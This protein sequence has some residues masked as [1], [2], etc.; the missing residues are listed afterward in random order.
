MTG[1][2]IKALEMFQNQPDQ[3]DLILTDQTMPE[4]TGA[5]LAKIILQIR[6]DV[7]IILCTGFSTIITEE[8]A[9]AIGIK[10]FV[11]KPLVKKDIAKLIRKV[12]DAS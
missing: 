7:P 10:E 8:K 9:K 5:E 3:F 4:M 11:F 2:S 12:L 6:Q 1:S